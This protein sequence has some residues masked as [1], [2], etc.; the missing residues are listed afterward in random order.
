M[1]VNVRRLLLGKRLQT[2]DLPH[3]SISKKVGLAVFASDALSSTAYATEEILVILSMAVGGGAVA[4][5]GR[6]TTIF[7]LSIPI[8]I[9]IAILLAIVTISYRQTIFAYPNGGGAYIVAR[10]NL[11]EGIAQVAGCAL[12]ID[13]VLTVSVSIAAGIANF[14][15][16]VHQ[17]FPSAPEWNAP[18]RTA[19]SLLVLF[20]MWYVNKRGV[21]ES[22]RAFAVPTYFFLGSTFLMLVVGFAKYVT[23]N[24]HSVDPN[25][26]GDVIHADRS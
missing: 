22:G 6:D 14:A 7:G 15:S 4:V 25:T 23:G 8:A 17:F 24:L 5:A 12:L 20:F 13:Y 19:A 21:K 10:D 11:G 2:D 3:Q 9:A 26:V 1:A 16:G 18:A